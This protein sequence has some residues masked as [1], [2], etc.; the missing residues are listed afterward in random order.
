LPTPRTSDTNGPGQ[1]GDG[2]LDLRTAVTLLPT[3]AAAD[4]VRGRNPNAAKKTATHNP[5]VNL[6]DIVW[7]NAGKRL[8][9]GIAVDLTGPATYPPSNDGKPSSDD[10]HPHLPLWE[11]AAETS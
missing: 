11:P 2:G 1:H 10:P 6:T 3:P 4:A 8:L 5:G 9:P 7:D